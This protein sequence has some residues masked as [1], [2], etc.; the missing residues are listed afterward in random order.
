MNKYINCNFKKYMF[1]YFL[2]ACLLFSGTCASFAQV[3]LPIKDTVAQQDVTDIFNLVFRKNKKPDTTEKK[4]QQPFFTS[5]YWI[6][7]KY[8]IH[9]WC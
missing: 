6:Y 8:R 5:F 2:T 7:A 4:K 3:K 9:V 1:R